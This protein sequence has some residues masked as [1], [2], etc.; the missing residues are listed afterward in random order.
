M[1]LG[2]SIRTGWRKIGSREKRMKRILVEKE[3]QTNLNLL[4]LDISALPRFAH[5][6][7][8]NSVKCVA[9]NTKIS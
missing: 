3:R 1:K 5:K 6:G 7:N 2:M 8:E 9:L 4:I